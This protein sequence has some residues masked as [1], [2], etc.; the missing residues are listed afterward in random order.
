VVGARIGYD[1]TEGGQVTAPG[2]EDELAA[3]FPHGDD[4]VLRAA[5][6]RYGALVY[7]IALASLPTPADAEEVTQATFVSAWQGRH[8]FNPSVGS[9]A[10]WLVGIVRRRAIDR[11]RTMHRERLSVQAMEQAA[12]EEVD[13]GP[14][15]VVDR[16]V[17]ADELGRLPDNQRRVLELAFFDDLTHSQIAALTGMPIG[18]VKSNLRR[19]LIQLRRRWEVD[20]AFAR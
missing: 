3:A 2:A 8:T 4:H 5:Y 9:L 7:R 13:V 14:E 18:T 12:G 17:I 15:R 16:I 11:L 20:G 19:G 6:D 1:R 10:G